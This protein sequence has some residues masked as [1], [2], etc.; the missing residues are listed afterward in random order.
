MATSSSYLPTRLSNSHIGARATPYI[1]FSASVGGG[2]DD[3][4]SVGGNSVRSTSVYSV[5]GGS[6][7]PRR[8]TMN[9][10]PLT[11]SAISNLPFY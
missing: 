9:Q 1:S 6:G 7:G 11:T 10:Q 3:A 4:G 8:R 2:V 5:G